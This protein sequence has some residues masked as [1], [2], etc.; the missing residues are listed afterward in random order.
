M[1]AKT[2]WALTGMLALAGMATGS[3][4]APQEAFCSCDNEYQVG[5]VVHVTV[6]PMERCSAG[7]LISTDGSRS[8]SSTG[9]TATGI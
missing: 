6:D 8:A 9:T 3:N 4:A 5:Q 1:R 2:S 7:I